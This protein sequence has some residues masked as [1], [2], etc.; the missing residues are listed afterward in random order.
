MVA[1][2]QVPP[3]SLCYTGNGERERKKKEKLNKFLIKNDVFEIFWKIQFAVFNLKIAD[4]QIVS[5]TET[6]KPFSTERYFF[7]KR[8]FFKKK[9]HL[10][11]LQLSIY[12]LYT[13]YQLEND[14]Q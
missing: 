13:M 10:F 12:N 8:S 3:F 5:T 7:F 9:K 6:R 1:V 2:Q 14:L 4:E 11:I